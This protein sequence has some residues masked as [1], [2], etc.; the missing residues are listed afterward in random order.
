MTKFAKKFAPAG[1][2]IAAVAAF[3]AP[4]A[5]HAQ[6]G[7]GVADISRA[8]ISTTALQSAYSQVNTTYATQLQ[9]RQTK[10]QQLTEL[11]RPFDSNGDGQIGETE[12]PA[13]QNSPNFAQFQTLESEIATL[14]SQVNNARIYAVEQVLA[15]Y[16]AALQEIATAQNIAVVLQPDAVQY[17]GESA[18]L[19]GAITA[20]LNSKVPS[21]GITPPANWRP[22][23]QGAQ[24]FQEIQQYLIAA[25]LRQQAAQQ[26]QQ[27]AQ[28]AP[29]GR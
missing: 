12:L 7:V 10:Q 17:A 2:V 13:V 9:S 22:S 16:P 6:T 27:P 26:Q 1:V 21:A 24:I 19:T 20:S 15:Q 4:M 23:R 5:A 29:Q 8:I 11:L 28:Q 14:N 25:Q 18:D 3:V